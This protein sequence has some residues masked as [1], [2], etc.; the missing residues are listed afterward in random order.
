MYGDLP[1]SVSPC[2]R[3]IVPCRSGDFAALAEALARFAWCGSLHRQSPTSSGSTRIIV[4]AATRK[5][6]TA[7]WTYA[8]SAVIPPHP[9]AIASEAA[10]SRRPRSSR[11]GATASNRCL[12]IAV[13]ITS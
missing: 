8:G 4:S 2:N 7:S 9:A 3:S 13:S 10:T 12:I 1:V 11:N 6:S 5:L